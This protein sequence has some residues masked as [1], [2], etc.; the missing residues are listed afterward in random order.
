LALFALITYVLLLYTLKAYHL[1]HTT[2]NV[3][4]PIWPFF[5]MATLG[6]FIMMFR[7]GLGMKGKVFGNTKANTETRT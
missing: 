1:G 2:P 7:I 6:S 3:C 4:L 5:A